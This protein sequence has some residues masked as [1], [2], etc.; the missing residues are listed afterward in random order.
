MVSYETET[1]MIAQWIVF[2]VMVVAAVAFAIVVQFRPADIKFPYYVNIAICTIAA[3]AYYVMATNYEDHN[4]VVGD[5]QVV[6][7]RYIDWVLTTPLLLLDLVL[8]TKMRG[9]T[10]AWIM[11][12]D[13]FMVIFGILGAFEPEHKFKWVYFIAGCVMQAVLTWGMLSVTWKQDLQKSKEYQ[14]SYISL[15]TFLIVLWV[16]YPVVWA[17]GSGT[18]L[19]DVDWEAILMGI[20]DVLAKPCFAVGCLIAHETIFKNSGGYDAL[21]E[22]AAEAVT[23]SA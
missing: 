8:M 15:L 18:G 7:A 17:F 6:Y 1:G 23:P 4:T 21:I 20:L 19:L 16:C 13:V 10:V 14:Q 2:G 12:A 9:V 22:K 11:V 5:R 3:C